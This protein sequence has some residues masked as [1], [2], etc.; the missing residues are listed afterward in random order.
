MKLNVFF[1]FFFIVLFAGGIY[2]AVFDSLV[3]L[4]IQQIKIEW[5]KN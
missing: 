2:D 3:S 5:K 1:G 4:F